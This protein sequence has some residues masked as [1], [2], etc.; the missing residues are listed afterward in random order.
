MVSAFAVP[1]L[2]AEAGWRTGWF[3]LGALGMA[4]TVAAL[5][6]LA[7]APEVAAHAAHRRP[8][9]GM[10]AARGLHAVLAMQPWSVAKR[11]W[12]VAGPAAIAN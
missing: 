4:A 7:R 6:A 10:H 11:F 8:A 9:V 3:V 5:P 2:V 1:A 12:Q